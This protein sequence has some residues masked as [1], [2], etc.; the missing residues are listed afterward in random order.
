M[1]HPTPRRPLVA[2][3][4]LPLTL[5][6]GSARSQEPD[7]PSEKPS[8]QAVAF[9]ENNIRPLLV[10]RC[11]E[12]HSSKLAEPEGGLLLDSRAGVMAGG[13]HG[14]VIV[15][16]KPDES[17][18]IQAIKRKNKDFQMPPADREPLSK[19]EIETLVKWVEMGVPDPRTEPAGAA[20]TVAASAFDWEKEA[21]HWAY[22]PV[23]DPHPPDGVTAEW[24]GTAVDRF[25]KAAL[26]AKGVTPVDRANKRTLIRR[27]TYDLTG[28]PPTPEEIHAFLEDESENAFEKVIDRLLASPRYGEQWGRHWMDVV[29]YADTGGDNSDFPIPS[30][31][32]YRNYT[33]DAFNT[34][35]P[36]DQF[37]REQ[38][39]GDLLPAKNH[40]DWQENVI[41]TGYIANARRFGSRVE[42]FHLTLD[43]T[44]ANLG[45]GILGLTIECA[46]CHDHKYDPITNEDYYA[47]YGIF[48]SSKYAFP[49]VE[50]TPRAADFVALGGPEE[51]E[52]LA[53]YEEELESLYDERRR[54]RRQLRRAEEGSP[55]RA[56]RAALKI[57]EVE[58]KLE[59]IGE[60]YLEIE[61]AY[62]V[63]EGDEPANA[64][65]LVRGDP[66]ILG[67]EVPRGFLTILGGQPVP[68]AETGSGRRQLAEWVTNPKNPVVPRVIVNRIW[69]WHF[70]QGIVRT[71]DD[72]GKRGEAPSHPQ[73]LDYL[74]R[75]FLEGGW[76]IK[77]MHKL[78]ML[79]RAYQ[80]SGEHDADNARKDP[81]NALLW[82]FS[83]RRLTAEEIRDTLLTV[84]GNLDE[85]KGE[86]HPFPPDLEYDYTQ[87][88]PFNGVYEEPERYETNRRSVYLLQ[89]RIRRHPFLDVWDGPDPNSVTGT[90]QENV[91]TIHA[92]FMMNSPFVHEQADSLSVRV[93]MAEQTD[94]ERLRYAYELLFARPPRS[95][96]IREVQQYLEKSRQA[97]VS[98][99]VDEGRANREAWASLM[100]VLIA[101]NEFL[102]LD[103][104]LQ[105]QGW[106]EWFMSGVLRGGSG[107]Q[108]AAMLLMF[109]GTL[110][111]VWVVVARKGLVP[112]MRLI[113]GADRLR[114][115]LSESGRRV[116]R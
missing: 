72:F 88:E 68:G 70:G 77:K 38:L 46:R 63:T 19:R 14:P 37:L 106:L 64:R 83:P 86:A 45:K 11:Y 52:L 100:R 79:T 44:L 1:A 32:R 82:R 12:C 104:A 16:G 15:P 51:Q 34:D 18:L 57:Y 109:A 60:K 25:V 111:M 107:V 24:N 41:A 76:S 55:A 89:Q 65:L 54:L 26:D 5:V 53:G 87:H 116:R 4:L 69:A 85:S 27:A 56:G 71:T 9:F 108:A 97:V 42:E 67:M 78:I 99:D 66:E 81:T 29:R 47:L 13:T 10:D 103:D 96:E 17:L 112:P 80:A 30:N 59:E 93:Y 115:R 58:R 110:S 22:Q 20:P 36:Y 114:R 92:L 23:R 98:N 105:P 40:A 6:A 75:R 90:R 95:D 7:S 48:K 2:L 101:S 28:L 94:A 73:L 102:T 91:T 33:I 39:A 21:K 35:K 31:Y 84:S 50:V 3:L 62:A 113:D 43:D 8:R 49:G 74:T 61:K